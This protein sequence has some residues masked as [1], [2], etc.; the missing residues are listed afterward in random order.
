MRFR[1]RLW[2]MCLCAAILARTSLESARVQGER[3]AHETLRDTTEE[4]ASQVS[5]RAHSA[6][7][8]QVVLALSW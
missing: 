2:L 5:K 1:V 3:R 8:K 4:T 6:R 7:A